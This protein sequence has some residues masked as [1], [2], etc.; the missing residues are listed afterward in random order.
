MG[1]VWRRLYGM[2]HGNVAGHLIRNE[3]AKLLRR[4][5]NGYAVARHLRR[6][7]NEMDVVRVIAEPIDTHRRVGVGQVFFVHRGRDLIVGERIQIAA[8]AIIDM[9]GHVHEVASA[10]NCAAL[11]VGLR[12]FLVAP[13]PV[14]DLLL[15]AK[16]LFIAAI[17][18]GIHRTEMIPLRGTLARPREVLGWDPVQPPGTLSRGYPARIKLV[19]ADAEV[20]MMTFLLLV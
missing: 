7:K 17:V 5:N 2:H 10:R 18:A 13:V 8:D 14:R 6:G 20:T 11:P 16:D 12:R 4:R 1:E 3:T 15:R 19:G 9:A